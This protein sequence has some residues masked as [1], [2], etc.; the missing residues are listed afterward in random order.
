MGPEGPLGR[1]Q[2][3]WTPLWTSS[4]LLVTTTRPLP[5]PSPFRRGVQFTIMTCG[6][7]T[8]QTTTR[9]ATGAA[10]PRPPGRILRIKT[11]YNPNSS[12]LGTI[13][14]AIPAAMV[15]APVVYNAI[16]AAF[17]SASLRD[18]PQPHGKQSA[19][20]PAADKDDSAQ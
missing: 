2:A 9:S 1:W 20:P 7:M 4:R 8:D 17:A 10:R 15:A 16:A 5:E 11:G 3:A 6:T 19:A 13:I 14:F 18:R 12:S